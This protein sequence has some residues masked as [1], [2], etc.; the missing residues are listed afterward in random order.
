MLDLTPAARQMATLVSG[1]TDEQLADRTPC[2]DYTLGDL[3]D[4]VGGLAQ[5]FAN[6]ATKNL[7]DSAAQA[8]PGD[9]SRL[10]D[11][12]RTRI[13]GQLA[14]LAAAW[15]DPAAWEGMTRAGGVDL[16]ADVAGQVAL[17]ELVIHGWDIA[18]ASRQPYRC[19]PQALEASLD[20]VTAMSV[21][22]E[23]AAREGLFGPVVPVPDDAPRL[24]R[25]AGLSGRDPNWPGP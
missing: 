3:I 14:E 25:V 12:W 5:A 1:V 2:P 21:P 20:F 16:P 7:G 19:D 22:G 24:D 23:E 4:H 15:Q 6:A 13:A 9:A 8:P 17:N 18:R 10:G 11:A